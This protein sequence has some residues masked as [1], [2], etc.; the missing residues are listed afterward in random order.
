MKLFLV[1][2][3]LLAISVNALSTRMEDYTFDISPLTWEVDVFQNGTMMN[4]TGTVEQVYAQI[5][6]INPAF[7]FVVPET[8][9]T[10]T[11]M[12]RT[13]QDP[14]NVCG[15]D[16]TDPQNWWWAKLDAIQDGQ[17]H[18]RNVPGRPWLDAGPSMCARVSCSWHSA[19]YWCNDNDHRIELDSFGQIA[20]CIQPITQD[21]DCLDNQAIFPPTKIMVVCGQH[22]TKDNWNCIATQDYEGC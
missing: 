5:L 15:R 13:K 9:E 6:E 16:K 18:L 21:P 2:F 17:W 14:N 4:M 3:R 12:A 7:E 10:E 1:L 19:I 20:D 8:N 11:L 22:F